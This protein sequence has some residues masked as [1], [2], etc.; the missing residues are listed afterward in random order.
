MLKRIEQKTNVN[1]LSLIF[2]NSRTTNYFAASQVF[3]K[4]YGKTYCI[5]CQETTISIPLF[6]NQVVPKLFQHSS[7][8]VFEDIDNF[9]VDKLKQK[10]ILSEENSSTNHHEE[11][12]HFLPTFRGSDLESRGTL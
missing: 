4:S 12:I 6:R 9:S 11:N 8:I 2:F 3:A 10:F 1:I 7:V 5:Q